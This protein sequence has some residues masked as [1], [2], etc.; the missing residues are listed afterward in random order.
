VHRCL[1][2]QFDSDQLE[3]SSVPAEIDTGAETSVPDP[4]KLEISISA[5]IPVFLSQSHRL[6]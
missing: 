3:F 2:K 1:K 5:G 4:A 6:N